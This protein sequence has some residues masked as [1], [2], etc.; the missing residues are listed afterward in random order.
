MTN[1]PECPLCGSDLLKTHRIG[2]IYYW[3]CWGCKKRFTRDLNFQVIEI[4]RRDIN[5]EGTQ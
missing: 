1:N 4:E 2:L 3:K 5:Q